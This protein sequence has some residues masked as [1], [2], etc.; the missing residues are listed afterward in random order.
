MSYVLAGNIETIQFNFIKKISKKKVKQ[1]LYFIKRRSFKEPLS[2][3]VK[4]K[5]FW[6]Y[7]FFLSSDV[8]DPRPETETL[9][10]YCLKKC[11]EKTKIIDVGTGSGCI[12]ISLAVELKNKNITA[13]DISEKILKIAKLNAKR[14]KVKIN[15]KKSFWFE[16]IEEKYD[17]LV[18]NPPYISKNDLL[19]LDYE[20]LEYDPLHSL[21]LFDDGLGAYRYFAKNLNIILNEKGLALFEIGS[22]QK[23]DVVDIFKSFGNK[24]INCFKDYYG[25]DRILCVK[26]DA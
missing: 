6:N 19:L 26:K 15:F 9:V 7:L 18:S 22:K 23:K 13:T 24:N 14:N 21:T 4:M 11:N 17:V 3:I 25:R 2:R 10:E 8:F 12:A 20:V 5:F 16:N 1:Y